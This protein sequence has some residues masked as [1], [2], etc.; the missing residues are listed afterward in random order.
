MV[1]LPGGTATLAHQHHPPTRTYE[2]TGSERGAAST[3]A[4]PA[5]RRAERTHPPRHD[6]LRAGRARPLAGRLAL[7]CGCVVEKQGGGAPAL[8]WAGLAGL[9]WAGLPR[10]AVRHP[11]S[12]IC[13]LPATSAPSTQPSQI[14]PECLPVLAAVRTHSV[15]LPSAHV[16]LPPA[17]SPSRHAPC[18]VGSDERHPAAGAQRGVV[19]CGV[20]CAVGWGVQACGGARQQ[21]QVGGSHERLPA[22]GAQEEGGWGWLSPPVETPTEN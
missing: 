9:R 22:S 5:E 10:C 11:R 4:A 8:R 21:C 15:R 17:T 3:A 18:A 13:Q 1:L 6:P 2:N 19:R 7:W 14:P 16:H 12:S 20:G